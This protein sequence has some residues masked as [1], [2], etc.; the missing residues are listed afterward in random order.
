MTMTPE[1]KAKLIGNIVKYGIYALVG[2][3]ALPFVITAIKGWLLLVALVALIG[4]TFAIAPSIGMM[5]SN[6]RLRMIKDEARRNPIETMQNIYRQK[7]EALEDGEKRLVMLRQ[8]RATYMSKLASFKKR[9]P[10]EVEY[11]D[12]AAARLTELLHI[13]EERYVAA[14]KATEVYAGEVEKTQAIWEMGKAAAEATAGPE[15]TE[16]TF[17]SKIK[18]ETAIDSARQQLDV[19]FSE[20]DQTL[21]EANEAEPRGGPLPDKARA[22]FQKALSQ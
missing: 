12:T 9:F 10:D 17:L 7:C 21:L 15:F 6:W 13:Q 4:G 2:F 14:R 8:K 3:I 11:F 22:A 18:N 1:Q 19:A 16:E 5:A 20:L